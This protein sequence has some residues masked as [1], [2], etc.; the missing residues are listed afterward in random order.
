MNYTTFNVSFYCRSSK[1]NTKGLAPIEMSI[2]I[3]G[4]RVIVTLPRKENP[5][6]FKAAIQAKRGN[7]I[8]DYLEATR[9]RLNTI[10]TEMMEQGILLNA[11]TLKEYFMYGGV[12]RL[13]VE[14]LFSEYIN[15][16]EKR[17]G[18]DLTYGTFKK[19]LLAR[20]KFFQYIDKN[21]PVSA[22]TSV[23]IVSFMSGLRKQYNT[24][25]ANGYGQKVKTIVNT[26]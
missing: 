6:L 5:K 9:K 17:V 10:T 20:E 7:E 26:L 19:Y 24:T 11:K 2:I 15:I 3:N 14:A 16:L 21:K 23:V 1:E 13:T 22:I 4:E 8:K 12:R 25:T 18:I